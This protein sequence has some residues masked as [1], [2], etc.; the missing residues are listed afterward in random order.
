MPSLVFIDRNPKQKNNR[1]PSTHRIM[2]HWLTEAQAT[3]H[4]EASLILPGYFLDGKK[5]KTGRK[6]LGVSE[7]L[8]C[9]VVIS[10]QSGVIV[11]ILQRTWSS[12]NVIKPPQNTHGERRVLFALCLTL[13]ALIFSFY[14]WKHWG[15]AK[16]DENWRDERGLRI[17]RLRISLLPLPS[18]GTVSSDKNN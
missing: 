6:V 9:W 16:V 10:V 4:F 17:C 3:E 15:P 1:W 2:K 13:Y 7:K 11:L 12:A 8:F 5:K 18:A 14:R